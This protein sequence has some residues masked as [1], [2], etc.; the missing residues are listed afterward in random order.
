MVQ[1]RVLYIDMV[2]NCRTPRH[3][4]DH[5]YR[6]NAVRHNLSTL[7]SHATTA[8]VIERSHPSQHETSLFLF[9]WP[10]LSEPT[11]G[12]GRLLRHGDREL[13]DRLAAKQYLH[14]LSP[15][16]SGVPACR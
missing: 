6:H 15:K 5:Y 10:S 14:M 9:S 8:G 11:A 4:D 13:E 2:S 12:L 16:S 1:G 7:C 3:N